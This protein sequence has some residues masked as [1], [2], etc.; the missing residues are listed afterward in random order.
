[1]Y[2]TPLLYDCERRLPQVQDGSALEVLSTHFIQTIFATLHTKQGLSFICLY[3][4]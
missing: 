1:M 2:V 3:T 4:V